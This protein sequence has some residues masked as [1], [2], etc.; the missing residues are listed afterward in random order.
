[1]SYL[2]LNSLILVLKV[3]GSARAL[4]HILTGEEITLIREAMGRYEP[5]RPRGWAHAVYLSSVQCSIHQ[6][7]WDTPYDSNS[8]HN[9]SSTLHEVG[10]RDEGIYSRARVGSGLLH[11]KCSTKY[12]NQF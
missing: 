10:I 3:T 2:A 8:L 9:L 1:M 6:F 7:S 11:W 4:K 5:P 12:F